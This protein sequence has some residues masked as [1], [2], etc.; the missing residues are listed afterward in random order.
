MSRMYSEVRPPDRAKRVTPRSC[1]IDPCRIA[2]ALGVMRVD[3]SSLTIGEQ[4]IDRG[5]EIT[6]AREIS[7]DHL[8]RCV[9]GAKRDRADP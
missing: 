2:A 5:L 3:V 8:A 7:V 6:S 1:P 9:E 4:A